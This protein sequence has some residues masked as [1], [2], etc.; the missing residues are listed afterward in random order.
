[1]ANKTNDYYFVAYKGIEFDRCDIEKCLKNYYEYHRPSYCIKKDDVIFASIIGNSYRNEP[2]ITCDSDKEVMSV[3]YTLYEQFCN[4]AL[5]KFAFYNNIGYVDE[6]RGNV[7]YGSPN[8]FIN[9]LYM[10]FQTHSYPILMRHMSLCSVTYDINTK[11]LIAGVT[12]P[13]NELTHLYYGYTKQNHE[14]MFSNYEKILKE[15]CD[16]IYEMPNYSYMKDGKIISY[17]N[18]NM[19]KEAELLVEKRGIKKY[20]EQGWKP[21]IA[22]KGS[23]YSGTYIR[24]RLERYRGLFRPYVVND[25]LINDYVFAKVVRDVKGLYWCQEP[26][27]LGDFLYVGGYNMDEMRSVCKIKYGRTDICLL[28]NEFSYLLGDAFDD[29]KEN[30]FKELGKNM[31]FCAVFWNTKENS[32]IAGVTEP[33]NEFNHL[34]YGYT[35]RSHELMF[36]NYLPELETYCSETHEIPSNSYM[37]D[38]VIYS[39]SKNKIDEE[40]ENY[41]SYISDSSEDALNY[42]IDALDCIAAGSSSLIGTKINCASALNDPKKIIE[43]ILIGL[44][45]ETQKYILITI[46]AHIE[47]YNLNMQH[48]EQKSIEGS[49]ET[50]N[51]LKKSLSNK[52]KK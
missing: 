22:Y 15:F 23:D 50:P 13:C 24:N 4:A 51:V 28:N 12:K 29:Y 41:L 39:F 44:D 34:Y 21:F 2:E 38:G 32:Y 7:V 27:L 1:M 47:Y 9:Y 5:E 17:E 6:N 52:D 16:E 49:D 31:H 42:A 19:I 8:K 25:K 40:R 3:C 37:K 18:E 46:K 20:N 11:S 26:H 14:L 45:Y 30:M 10:D 33:D 48:E 36:S 43:Y 35:K